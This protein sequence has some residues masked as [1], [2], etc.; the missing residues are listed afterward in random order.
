MNTSCMYETTSAFKQRYRGVE[1]KCM[2][3]EHNI[4]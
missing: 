2:I 4:G 3:K 1:S